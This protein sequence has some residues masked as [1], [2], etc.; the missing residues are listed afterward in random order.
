[1]K[2]EKNSVI[3][4]KKILLVQFLHRIAV[5]LFM[6]CHYRF[7]IFWDTSIWN[8][9]LIEFK[10]RSSYAK[11]INV[12]LNKLADRLNW[13][14]DGRINFINASNFKCMGKEKHCKVYEENNGSLYWHA[15]NLSTISDQ[16]VISH[17]VE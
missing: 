7:I 12:S 16:L 9:K 3:L 11:K 13:E 10:S 14:Y 15:N 2:T 5:L 17:S 8:R 6:F 1:M 4:Q